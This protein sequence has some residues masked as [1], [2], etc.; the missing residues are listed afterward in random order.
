MKSQMESGEGLW[1]GS[2]EG[3]RRRR[4]T[5]FPSNFFKFRARR[6]GE[7]PR[8]LSSNLE[9]NLLMLSQDQLLLRK[10]AKTRL[11]DREICGWMD[12]FLR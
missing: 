1:G 3:V 2:R 4:N 12:S 10:A 5:G 7:F 11:T 9:R 6:K 8:G